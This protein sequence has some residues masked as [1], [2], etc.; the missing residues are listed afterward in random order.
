MHKRFTSLLTFL[1]LFSWLV[2]NQLWA[3]SRPQLPTC[4]T[5]DLTVEQARALVKQANLALE[6]K[7][8]SGAA[9]TAITYVPI[10]PH[11]F[12]KSNGT[13]G[14]SLANLN[15]VMAITN[16]YYLSNGY[17]I[18]FYF[19]G[20]SP[21]YID[22]DGL[23][24]NFPYP[25]GSSVDGRD[26]PN[27]MNQYYVNSFA[28]PGL[29][30]YAYYPYDALFST[31]SF[32]VA[33]NSGSLEYLG[34]QLIPHELGHNF[35]L[36][37]TFGQNPGNGTL[38][39]GTTTELVTRGAGANCTTD[40]DLI[41]DTP[42]DPY[43]KA[44]ASTIYV[45][46]CPQYDP[47]STARDANGAPYS[48]SITNIM[49]YY[50]PC[51]H[52]FTAGQF[53]RMQA[54]LALRQSHTNYSLNAPPSN[55]TAPSNLIASLSGTII[56][57]TWQDNSDN[58]MGFFIE[59]ST[60]PNGSFVPVGGVGPNTTTFVDSK[61]TLQTRYYYRIRPSNTTTG[62][63]SSTI[64]I[65]VSAGL[66]T[67]LVGNSAQLTWPALGTG[68]TYE[69]QWRA[70]GDAD[71]TSKS[72]IPS[73]TTI[74]YGLA[75]N[76][77]YEWRVRATGS[78]RYEGP[79]RFTIPCLQPTF[80]S[81]YSSRTSANI[82]WNGTAPNQTYTLRWRAAGT[83]DW[84][85]VNSLTATSYS[86]TGLSPSTAY[87]WQVQS[88]CLPT[89]STDF[90]ALQTFSTLSCL[91]PYSLT[92]PYV[93]SAS[94]YVTWY[95]NYYEVGR[96]SEIRYRPVGTAD[97]KVI[98]GLTTTDYTFT[99]LANDTQYEWQV[100]SICSA[101]D[102]SD[103]SPSSYFTTRCLVP[104]SLY[105]R[106]T[107]TGAALSW[108]INGSSES[109][110]TYDIQ[111]RPSGSTDWTTVSNQ[112]STFFSLTGL[113]TNSS[114]EWRVSHRCSSSTQSD[115]SA[116]AT[117]TTQCNVPFTG[118]LY[119]SFVTSSSA[120]L[121]WYVEN[122]AGTT[123][124]IRYRAVGSPDW[125]TVSSL[126][127]SLSNGSYNVTGLANN[128]TYE[129]QVKTT[130]SPSNNTAFVSGPAFTTRCRMPDN[131][132]TGTITVTSASL[133]WNPTGIDVRY[134]LRY[135]RVGS[136]DWISRDNLTGSAITLTDL[137]TGTNYEWQLRTHCQDDQYSDYSVTA[138]F[139]TVPC[140]VP[141]SLYTHTITEN[142]ATFSWY[143]YGGTTDTR[144]EIRWRVVGS[145]DWTIVSNLS[146]GNSGTYTLS[147]L[148][149]S[150]Q[151][152]WQIR[153]IC[154]PTESSAFS[155]SS[156]FQTKAA[157]DQMYTLRSGYWNE[158]AIWSCGRLPMAS[159]VVRLKHAVTLPPTYQATIRSI[160]YEQPVKLTWM[161]G[162]RLTLI[163]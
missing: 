84:T 91:P 139:S 48:P 118:G 12:R 81:A 22:N 74:L 99:G 149:N 154:S 107:A 38:G 94:A 143:F 49:S 152:E 4:G 6:R 138:T 44:G 140:S 66:T 64:D 89:V 93:V 111:Y 9:F 80:P 45:N 124:E 119:A 109:N 72:G 34:N 125:T 32:I 104:A 150:T 21:D 20:T 59:R 76:A 28:N 69:V 82:Y 156:T 117:F 79:V 113:Q 114:Y 96:Q 132:Y 129:W 85:T 16:S 122:E 65:V 7:R 157:C 52:D 141:N 43:N 162:A 10:R 51:T 87:E 153:S 61:T 31:R 161:A 151:Y 24:S 98:S 33:S 101:A 1:L 131:M 54:A 123:Y 30:G 137:A 159:D 73:N 106:A 155:N 62:S 127:A 41:C 163:Q 18:Q 36:I 25:E 39:S 102:Q 46:G 146:I 14:F 63:L 56:T 55:V 5:T 47:N 68:I 115:Y 26:A 103:F 90:I 11:I 75:S 60:S 78:D 121:Y 67:T 120:Q 144:A 40:G 8:A 148:A 97:W 112:P 19:S 158:V 126:T 15:Q 92:A 128:T 116:V 70:V 160:F 2:S 53:D 86:L 147:G 83:P 88:V 134:D 110:S 95:L 37:H 17:G 105:S 71:W 58:E 77:T 42:A 13:E 133:N 108:Y 130:C 35:S 100:R 135:R 57:L 23:Y 3:Q 27:A 50:Y 29:G 142:S 145:A 136:A